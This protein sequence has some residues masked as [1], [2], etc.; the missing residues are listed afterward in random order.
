M[1]HRLLLV[2]LISATLG[3]CGDRTSQVDASTDSGTATDLAAADLN[4]AGQDLVASGDMSGCPAMKPTP[5]TAC[6]NTPGTVTGPTCVY[7]TGT[8]TCAD[9]SWTC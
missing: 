9:A 3:G 8:C 4:T 5:F 1:R 6:T 2:A 7:P